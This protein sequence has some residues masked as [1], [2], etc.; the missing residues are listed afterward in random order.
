MKRQPIDEFMSHEEVNWA[1][2]DRPEPGRGVVEP[3][4]VGGHGGGS[5]YP[6]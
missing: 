2:E 5:T 3:R 1:R 4:R 6:Y